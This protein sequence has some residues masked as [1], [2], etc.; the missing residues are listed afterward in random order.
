MTL[1]L[2]FFFFQLK[3]IENSEHVVDNLPTLSFMGG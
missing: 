2:F 1:F 3:L